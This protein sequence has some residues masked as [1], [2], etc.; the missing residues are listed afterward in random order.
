MQ[1]GVAVSPTETSPFPDPAA[2]IIEVAP[3]DA[4]TF[5]H[6]TS[7]GCTRYLGLTTDLVALAG[8][9]DDRPFVPVA[10]PDEIRAN[11]ADVLILHDRYVRYL[12]YRQ[13]GWARF[14]AFPADGPSA[15][16][17]RLASRVHR[18]ERLPQVTWGDRRYDVVR[19]RHAGQ[20]AARHYLSPLVSLAALPEILEAR[21]I[22]YVVLRWFDALPD[23]EPG[24]DLDI[25]VADDDLEALLDVLDHSPGTVPVDVYSTAGRPGADFQAM[26]YYPPALATGILDRAVRLPSGY[27]APA[28]ADHFLS[29]SYHALYHK[30]TAAGL[31]TVTDTP[32]V[33]DPAEHDYLAILSGLAAEHGLAGA[34]TMERLDDHLA[35]HGWRPPRDMLAKLSQHNRWVR[36]R[37]FAESTVGPEPPLL[38]AFLL[39]DRAADPASVA[40][41]QGVMV[42]HG[43]DIVH[44]HTLDGPARERCAREIRGGN[45]GQGP[46]P[47]SGGEPAVLVVA[48][49][50]HPEPPGPAEQRQHPGLANA[51]TLRAKLDV[52]DRLLAKVP[53]AEQFNPM[54]SSDSDDD[55]WHYVELADPDALPGLRAMVDERRANRALGSDPSSDRRPTATLSAVTAT[56]RRAARA[57]AGKLRRAARRNAEGVLRWGVDRRVTG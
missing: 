6:F 48:L 42:Q 10:A 19:M 47:T 45:W 40:M 8:A 2:R 4:A 1:G 56:A 54:H 16:E 5:D 38:T 55:G 7:V 41:A 11:N 43:F 37:F 20:V 24:E 35:A 27:R 30:G 15:A 17:A 29:L 32:A 52:R 44:V 33:G 26:A 14:V 9:A 12:W 36:D 51:H 53:D 50:E 39:R 18:R 21:G 49:H 22:R 46:F 34:L 57:T 23:V 13:L 31:P 25:L 3:P 28:P